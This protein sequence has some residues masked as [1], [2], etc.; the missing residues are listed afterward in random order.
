MIHNDEF[1]PFPCG[2]VCKQSMY[3]VVNTYKWMHYFEAYI[4]NISCEKFDKKRYTGVEG[5]L[6]P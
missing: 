4:T 5:V 6:K 3:Y 2:I 1:T